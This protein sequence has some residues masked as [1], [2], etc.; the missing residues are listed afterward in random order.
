MKSNIRVMKRLILSGIMAAAAF[1][2]GGAQ[3]ND[4]NYFSDLQWRLVGPHR[5]GRVW[6][7]TGV[8]GDP[9]TYY[10]GTPAGALWKSTNGG[11]TWASISDSLPAT[12]VGAVAVSASNSN[13]LYI[14]TG[15]NALG[16]GVFRSNDA[17][18][19]WQ[20]AGLTDSK[21]ITGLL[22]DPRNPDVVIASVGAGGNFG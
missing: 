17:G 19:T 13:I 16:R 4:A 21:F 9:A 8:A 10:A 22:I 2:A 15:S 14:G 18:R 7:V 3:A 1:T 5:A 20:P 6:W 12:G 11:T